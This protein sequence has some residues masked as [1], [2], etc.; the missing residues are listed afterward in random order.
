M[1]PD[2][3]RSQKETGVPVLYADITVEREAANYFDVNGV[4][5]LV[6]IDS[7]KIVSEFTGERSVKE[8]SSFLQRNK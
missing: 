4:P 6:K 3:E 5:L 2:V 1:K 7:G 8:I